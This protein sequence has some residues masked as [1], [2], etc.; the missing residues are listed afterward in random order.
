MNDTEIISGCNRFSNVKLIGKGATANVYRAD[1]SVIQNQVAVKMLHPHLAT[2]EISLERFKRE[3]RITRHLNHSNIVSIHD[4]LD[5]EGRICLV[6][7]YLKGESLKKYLQLNHPIPVRDVISV[8]RSLAEILSECHKKNVIHRDLKPHNI[9]IFSDGLIKLLDFGIARMTMLSDLTKTGVSLGSPE[10]MAPELFA[11]GSYDP[12]TDVYSLGVIAFELLTGRLP[13]RGDSIA[14]LFNEHLKSSVPD[15]GQFR[16][17]VPDWVRHIT[18][19]LLE[20]KP[21]MRYQCMDELLLDLENEKV[22]S[23][24]MPRLDRHRCIQCGGDTAEEL[25]FCTMC[26]FGFSDISHKGRYELA[27]TGLRG[28]SKS[29]IKQLKQFI[30]E[31]FGLEIKRIS[32]QKN[33]L[34]S[35]IDEFFAESVKKRALEY[36]IFLKIKKISFLKYPVILGTRIPILL[37]LGYLSLSSSLSAINSLNYPSA[38][39][40]TIFFAGIGLLFLIF[41]ISVLR[42]TNIGV[43][44]KKKRL[45]NLRLYRDIE[46][47]REAA[48][49]LKQKRTDEMKTV[50]AEATEQFFMLL[51]NGSESA[52]IEK[53]QVRRIVIQLISL[54]NLIS[55]IETALSKID[56][57]QLTEE[58][59]NANSVETKSAYMAAISNCQNLQDR[60]G[61]L[62][63]SFL[64]LR[65][66]LNRIF[67]E[68]AVL[69]TGLEINSL[70]DF[71]NKLKSLEKEFQLL[72]QAGNEVEQLI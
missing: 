25:P 68:A 50:V 24:E 5:I 15:I 19:K 2:D 36:N 32:L 8:I 46:W 21:V 6:M 31:V 62:T 30:R 52:E 69:Q 14:V 39:G 3:I 66:I 38:T 18:G 59:H 43:V 45:L 55:E 48:V 60:H 64:Y 71:E 9:F 23:K 16:E 37:L 51:K 61:E 27:L 53:D 65:F 72:K 58:Y 12:R 44:I 42:N 56:W 28:A 40:F 4:M 22:I 35:G 20:K 26:G 7:E 1:D 49:L 54:S 70:N 63:N 47:L 67:G 11:T 17:D 33:T 57:L 41:F 10:Y 29:D 34:L 13:F